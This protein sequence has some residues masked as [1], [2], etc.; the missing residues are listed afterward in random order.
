MAYGDLKDLPKRTA[1]DNVLR[2]KVFKIASDQK[3][4][5]F[6][7]GL[8]S[9]VYEFFDKKS[10]GKGLANNKENLQLANELHN[11]IIKKI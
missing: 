4:D 5:G 11:S 10:Q 2:D 6:Q 8:A 9:M 7:R 1:A 3:Y